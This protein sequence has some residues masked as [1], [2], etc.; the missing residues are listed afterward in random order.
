MPLP[1]SQA[2]QAPTTPR[3]LTILGATGSV[4]SSTVDLVRRDPDLYAVEAV[5]ANRNAAALA[6]LAVNLRA[7][8]AV[9]ADAEGYREL[10]EA[11]SGTG[12]EA[13]AGEQALVEAAGRPADWIMAAITGASG[14]A[15]TLSAMAPGR[16]I[17]LANKECLVCAGTLFMRQAAQSEVTVLPADSEH[18][19]IF[20][21][22]AA[23][24]RA[25]V[26]QI[27]I[28]ASGGPFRTTSK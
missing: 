11:L 25:D 22:I 13:A 5:T 12:I 19:A 26:R 14:L 27:I 15:P 18:N 1:D 10:K 3:R 17:A 20:Q 6:A 28:T 7:K 9:V 21:A 16:T 2:A 4:G 23:G 24:D 8:V